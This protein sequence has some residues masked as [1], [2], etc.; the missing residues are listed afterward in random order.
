MTRIA[1]IDDW[2][3]VAKTS[4]DWTALKQR[5]E[6]VFFNRPLG[7]PD[8]IVAALTDFD[9]ILA[10]RERT[11]FT[12]EIIARLPRLKFFNMTGQRA[13]GLDD[14]VRAGVT[15]STT[16]GG[17][18]AGEDTAEHALA[19]ILAAVR[20]IPAG[21]AAVRAGRFQE[22]IAPGSRLSGKTLGVLGLG[23]IGG[24]LAGYGRALGMNV[25]AWSRS[26]TDE[27]AAA[28]GV[29]PVSRDALFARSDIV[30]IHL[31]LSGETRG[32]VDAAALARMRPGAVLVNTSRAPIV[33]E[34]ALL[35]ALGEK[36]IRAALDVFLEEPLPPG[37]AL[38]TAPN[39]VLTPHLGYATLEAYA[40][41]YRS[42]IEN[43]LAF[44][45]GKPMRRY[46]PAPPA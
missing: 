1:V 43:A 37:H 20:D 46:E 15:V 28:A 39:T 23:R 27:R 9:A 38:A 36:R 14:L 24:K 3:N 8:A 5:A 45:D 21:D 6:L 42:S 13:R 44:L 10:M 18:D 33:D 41:F 7:P 34:P 35:A 40:Q 19:L 4:A 29:E 31:V 30:S 12:S 25:I 2:Q 16:G 32:M 26:M 11:I 22:G 17:G